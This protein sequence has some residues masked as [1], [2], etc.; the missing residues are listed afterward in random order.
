MIHLKRDSPIYHDGSQ[1]EDLMLQVCISNVL[2]RASDMKL[3]SISIPAISSGI[4]K[5][6]K[7]LCAQLLFETTLNFFAST[8]NSS[9]TTVR[10]TNFDKETVDYFVSEFDKRFPDAVQQP[11]PD[12]TM[13]S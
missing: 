5:F 13:T 6:P 8:S 9:V 3:T 1:G 2:Q 12:P 7:P 4:F 10:F 11:K